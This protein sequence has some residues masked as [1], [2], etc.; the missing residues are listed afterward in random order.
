M[1]PLVYSAG[2]I[3]GGLVGAQLGAGADGFAWGVLVGSALGPFALPLYG[4][5]ARMRWSMSLSFSNPTCGVPLAV[6]SDHDR[7]LDRRRRRVDREEPSLLS[8]AGALS[9]LQYGRTLMKVPIGMFGM[10]AG[11][12]AYPP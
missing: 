8:P 5:L 12:A 11:V 4:C 7:L 10:A 3:I 6:V 2:I 9:Q 1:A